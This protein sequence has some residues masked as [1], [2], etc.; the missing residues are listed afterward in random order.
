MNKNKQYQRIYCG[1]CLLILCTLP[2]AAQSWIEV[3]GGT[4]TMG[5]RVVSTNQ[6][7]HYTPKHQVTVNDFEMT[8]TEITI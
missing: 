8:A 5:E 6:S 7:W 1:L 4:F 3:S 2:L